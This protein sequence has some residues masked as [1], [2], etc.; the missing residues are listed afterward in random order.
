MK[1]SFDTAFQNLM[2]YEGGFVMNPHDPGGMTNLGV[3]KDQWEKNLG[4]PCDEADM[5]ALTRDVVKPF[6]KAQYWDAIHGD[7][8][9]RGVDACVFDCCVNSGP[10]RAIKLLQEVLGLTVDGYIG[11]QTIKVALERQPVAIIASYTEARIKYLKGL[12]TWDIFG[13]GWGTR[14]IKVGEEARELTESQ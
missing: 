8:L 9:P 12:P 3:T 14:V 5:R 4:H 6:Y 2:V 10:S 1:A 11:P 7:Y 13:K